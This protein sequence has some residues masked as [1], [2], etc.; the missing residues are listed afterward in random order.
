MPITNEIR[1]LSLQTGQD[2]INL[3]GIGFSFSKEKTGE[4][5]AGTT[6]KMK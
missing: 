4:T 5:T 6:S 3:M 1:S 2:F